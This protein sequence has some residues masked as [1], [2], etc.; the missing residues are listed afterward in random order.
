MGFKEVSDLNAET[1]IS[2]GGSNRKTGKTNPKSIE[3]YYLG[4]KKVADKMKGGDAF[5]YIFQTPKGNVG[6]WGK[7]DLIRKMSGVVPGTMVRASHVGMQATPKGEMYKYKVEIDGDNTIEVV[8][9]DYTPEPSNS[10]DDDS[11]S[12]QSE[13]VEE[14]ED[15]S[16]DVEAELL[17]KQLAA[18]RKAKVQDLLK[19]KKN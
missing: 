1:T 5:I 12:A 10:H 9:G 16:A 14:S 11:Y 3:G 8:G 13:S 19:S 18:A 4:F 6:V 15:D 2:L 7:T 17:A